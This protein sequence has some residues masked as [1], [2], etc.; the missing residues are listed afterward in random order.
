MK[1]IYK[2]HTISHS[3]RILE[4]IF[5]FYCFCLSWKD[6]SGGQKFRAPFILW[7]ILF[8]IICWRHSNS[9]LYSQRKALSNT[10]YI[11]ISSM[12]YE[13]EISGKPKPVFF[14]SLKSLRKLFFD[15]AILKSR[16]FWTKWGV[17]AFFTTFPWEITGITK[18]KKMHFLVHFQQFF[19]KI[20]FFSCFVMP[21]ISQGKV[22]K[23]AATPHFV[24]NFLLFKMA[25]S[26]NNFHKDFK[27]LKNTG[28]G[29]VEISPS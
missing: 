11:R 2:C 24:Q 28:F 12:D 8:K 13:S 18:Y 5:L 23:N 27:D 9:D 10:L 7:I 14:R 21:V 22:V 15:K 29:F 25:L 20:H 3:H 16:K 19:N 1:D 4:F 26:K 6:Y 17:A